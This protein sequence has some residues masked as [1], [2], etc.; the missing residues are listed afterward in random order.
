M[1]AVSGE[2]ARRPEARKDPP[3]GPRGRRSGGG[4]GE[5]RRGLS[6]AQGTVTAPGRRRVGR[7]R[8]YRRIRGGKEGR[9]GEKR[10]PRTGRIL[11]YLDQDS[12]Q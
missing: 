6:G 2:A 10:G 3:E 9:T 11:S 12:S 4:P 1:G 8:G 7:Y 5:G